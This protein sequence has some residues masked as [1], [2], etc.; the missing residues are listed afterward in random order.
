MTL[1]GF[2]F[3]TRDLE[4]WRMRG[5]MK[6]DTIESVQLYQLVIQWRV[7][8]NGSKQNTYFSLYVPMLLL[9]CD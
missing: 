9:A 3:K 8:R 7:Y 5:A 6:T 4:Q 1:L 2:A